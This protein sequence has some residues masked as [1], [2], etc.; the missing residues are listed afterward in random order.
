[1]S[2]CCL[3]DGSLEGVEGTLAGV[4]LGRGEAGS[5]ERTCGDSHPAASFPYN[6][7]DP[8]GRGKLSS[9]LPVEGAG[10][11]LHGNLPASAWGEG[12]EKS[13]RNAVHGV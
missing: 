12:K 9:H 10:L 6:L 8:L 1:M 11:H 4:P 3:G 7:G 5:T 2:C 13:E